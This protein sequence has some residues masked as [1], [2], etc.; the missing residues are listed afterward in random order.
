[1]K[2]GQPRTRPSF[3]GADLGSSQARPTSV[4]RPDAINLERLAGGL[5]Q[6][7]KPAR[8]IAAGQRG[9]GSQRAPVRSALASRRWAAHG[10]KADPV[11]AD[12]GPRLLGSSRERLECEQVAGAPARGFR[13]GR[14]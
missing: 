10:D 5:W 9:K 7:L 12:H 6:L 11:V 3:P 8:R 1:M 4:L 14:F 2:N 13:C